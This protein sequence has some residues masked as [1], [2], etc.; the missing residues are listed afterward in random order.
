MA[1]IP[2]RYSGAQRFL[3]W[4]VF[5]C[6]VAAYVLIELRSEAERGSA[7]RTGLTQ[8]HMLAGLAVFL[9]AWPRIALRLMRGAPPITPPL[10]AWQ[11]LPAQLTHLAL[12]AFLIAQPILGILT[13]WSAGRGI[14]IFGTGLE[15]PALIAENHDLHEQLEDL[16]EGLGEIFYWVIGLHIAGAIFHHLLRRDDTLR[17][18]L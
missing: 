18:M 11:H 15:I 16:H 4:F 12:Y 5:A 2:S 8:G 3:H 17:R 13:V 6:I 1:S 14:A 7:L 9:L 10:P